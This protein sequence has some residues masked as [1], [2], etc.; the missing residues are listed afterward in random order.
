[1][2]SA[3]LTAC[4]KQLKSGHGARHEQ[5][6]KRSL[7]NKMENLLP[8][9]FTCDFQTLFALN[10]TKTALQDVNKM[11]QSHAITPITLKT[12]SVSESLNI[13]NSANTVHDIM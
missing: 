6:I 1:M 11:L 2:K 10:S 9:P 3:N 7:D 8:V 5:P 4:C 12:L 13:F